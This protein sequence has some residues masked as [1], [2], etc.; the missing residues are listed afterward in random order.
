MRHMKQMQILR[1]IVEECKIRIAA[2][3]IAGFGITRDP[4]VLLLVLPTAVKIVGQI[5]WGV[6]PPPPMDLV[7]PGFSRP[8]GSCE[9]KFA[10]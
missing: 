3:T 7:P 6:L 9:S 2:D 4:R 8:G 10:F 1:L 5:H